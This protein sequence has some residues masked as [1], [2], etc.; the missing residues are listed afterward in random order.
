M[1]EY[2]ILLMFLLILLNFW[3]T[4][5]LGIIWAI[6]GSFW[7]PLGFL[8]GTPILNTF[9]FAVTAL[10]EEILWFVLIAALFWLGYKR[11][12][13]FLALVLVSSVF[14]NYTLK[15]IIG[16][17]RPSFYEVRKLEFSN[18]PSFPSGH[19]QTIS[20]ATFTA[21]W[22]AK[23][24]AP[25]LSK[26]GISLFILAAAISVLV[27]ISRIYLGVHWPTDVIAGLFIGLLVFGAYA[28]IA[29]RAWNAINAKIKS[30]W[31]Y[32]AIVLAIFIAIP[33]AIPFQWEV[34]WYINI[35][36]TSYIMGTLPFT[37]LTVYPFEW[38]MSW[39]LS[40]V[41]AGFLS[42][43]ALEHKYVQLTVP[44]SRKHAAIRLV[45]GVAVA[46][47]AYFLLAEIP[48]GPLQFPFYAL[49]GLWVTLIAPAFFKKIEPKKP[50]K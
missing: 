21:A 35:L 26:R 6:Q 27:A 13:V 19:A 24:D 36:A 46:L 7:T 37:I 38:G 4:W 39:Y 30:P 34:N 11:E 3:Y 41:I 20:T 47:A 14:I 44:P 45:I 8:G 16:R 49:L 43:A 50:K 33:V 18:T 1:E 5:D 32:V 22:L 31:I 25:L 48:W 40:G 17:P 2:L 15:Y 10:G 9:W 28:L 12:G 29:N 23:K 42:G